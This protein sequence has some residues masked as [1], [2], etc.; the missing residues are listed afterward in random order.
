MTP[1][2][3]LQQRERELQRLITSPAGREELRTLES[4]Y[5]ATCGKVR[6]P[7]TSLITF[8]IVFE[9]EHGLISS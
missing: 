4:S 9:R 1:I 6:P 3:T 2:P 5:S 7:R 8:L